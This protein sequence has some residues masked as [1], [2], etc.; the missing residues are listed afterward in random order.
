MRWK[1]GVAVLAALCLLGVR[2]AYGEEKGPLRISDRQMD[3]GTEQEKPE[4]SIKLNAL[5][6]VLMDGDTGRV[7]YGKNQEE[8]RP[9]ASTTKIMTCILALEEGRPEEVVTASENAASQP[10]VHLGV[11]AGEQFYLEDLLYGLM[12]ESYNDAAVMIAEHIGGS[13]E[14]FAE[15]MNQKAREL[16]CVNT[17]FITPNGLDA[18]VSTE[19]GVRQ[20]HSTT[21]EELARIMA[22]CVNDSPSREEFLKI[23]QS[24]NYSFSDLEGKRSFSCVNHNAL[25][26]SMDGMISGKTGFTSG[27]GYSYVGAVESEGRSFIIAILGCGWPPH[28]SWKWT[29]A[30]ALI[31]YGKEHYHLR[32]IEPAAE[33]PE[34]PVENGVYWETDGNL[35]LKAAEGEALCFLLGDWEGVTGRLILP[36]SAEAPVREGQQ[37]G[38]LEYLTGG[39]KLAM[40]PVYAKQEQEALTLPRCIGRGMELFLTL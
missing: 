12:L 37:I 23:T 31:R 18:A 19:D 39:E 40:V 3:E 15:K 7:L 38:Q 36:Q 22:Y 10:Q 32:E 13:T 25:L 1:K 29:D 21:A 26:S 30:A 28:K 2:P 8:I 24:Q 20:V 5:A 34:I 14:Q 6:A 33:L 17:F 16:G 11:K 27:A 9:M 35:E 4:E